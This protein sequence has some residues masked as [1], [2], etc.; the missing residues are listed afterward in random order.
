VT[1]LQ[2]IETRYGLSHEGEIA[3]RL[4][5]VRTALVA[6]IQEKDPESAVKLRS[7]HVVDLAAFI[8]SLVIADRRAQN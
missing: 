5:R 6:D 3:E 1:N 4:E 2:I 8:N 7:Y